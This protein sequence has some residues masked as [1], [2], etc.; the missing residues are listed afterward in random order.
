MPKNISDFFWEFGMTYYI[1]EYMQLW[2]EP[3]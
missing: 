3:W 1:Q 2:W